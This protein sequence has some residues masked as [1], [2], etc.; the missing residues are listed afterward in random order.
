MYRATKYL[1]R[2]RWR[3]GELAGALKRYESDLYNLLGDEHSENVTD[4]LKEM[5]KA[6]RITERKF[7]KEMAVATPSD[8]SERLQSIPGVG[9][10][11]AACI[12]GEI[13]DMHRFRT[14]KELIAFAGLYPR[15]KQ[16]GHRLNV[17]GRLTKRGSHYLRHNL[18]L[19]ASVARQHTPYFKALQD[20]KWAEGK[21]YTVACCLVSR[22]Q[23]VVILAMCLS[24]N[25][26]DLNQTSP[27]LIR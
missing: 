13:Q 11:I 25:K 8:L 16:S 7:E 12:I 1:V 9:P 21:S 17:T 10:C 22:K 4:A 27:T 26:Y 24:G 3:I 14:S 18:F 2:G 15:I 5:H 20:K 23:L 19:T 6:F